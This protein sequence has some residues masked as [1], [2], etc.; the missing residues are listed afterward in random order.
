MFQI[1]CPQTGCFG[2]YLLSVAFTLSFVVIGEIPARNKLVS[3]LGNTVYDDFVSTVPDL[4]RRS[5]LS[6]QEK[7]QSSQKLVQRKLGLKIHFFCCLLCNAFCAFT[8]YNRF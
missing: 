1:R 7:I 8:S 3:H 5:F 6:V 4:L 2:R